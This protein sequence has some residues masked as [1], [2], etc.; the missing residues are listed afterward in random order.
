MIFALFFG[1]IPIFF[2]KNAFRPTKKIAQNIHG[3]FW[4]KKN[5]IFCE[6][7]KKL[8]LLY[9]TSIPSKFLFCSPS[10][11]GQNEPKYVF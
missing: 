7:K 2:E 1:Y 11:S 4:K 9:F 5:L 10:D 8:V 3:Y 6:K